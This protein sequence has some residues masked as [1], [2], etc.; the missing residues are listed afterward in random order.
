RAIANYASANGFGAGFPN[1]HQADHGN[2]LVYGVAFLRPEHVVMQDVL[3]DIL[4]PTP[5]PP[6]K[7]KLIQ[8]TDRITDTYSRFALGN[9]G[10]VRVDRFNVNFPEV[11][12]KITVRAK[13]VALG[14]TFF[15]ITSDVEGIIDVTKPEE[16]ADKFTLT[17][18][19]PLGNPS[20]SL[21]DAKQLVEFI[22]VVL[23]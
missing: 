21:E 4:E 14:Q 16:S 11:D 6:P 7:E 1:F 19:T 22:A 10:F 9:K 20:L 3:R 8:I 5:P 18:N 15:S 23:A 2:G 17:I 13:E 12:L